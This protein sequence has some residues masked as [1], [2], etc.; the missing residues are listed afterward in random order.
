[1]SRSRRREEAGGGAR[2]TKVGAE[3]SEEEVKGFRRGRLCTRRRTASAP[4]VCVC[5]VNRIFPKKEETFRFRTSLACRGPL[6]FFRQTPTLVANF[7]TLGT[8]KRGSVVARVPLSCHRCVPLVPSRENSGV[9][10]KVIPASGRPACFATVSATK[11]RDLGSVFACLAPPP[12]PPPLLRHFRWTFLKLE[13]IREPLKCE[14]RAIFR[15]VSKTRFLQRRRPPRSPK[16]KRERDG[17]K[18]KRRQAVHSTKAGRANPTVTMV[19]NPV[20]PEGGVRWP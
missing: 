13:S 10:V 16:K 9:V 7:A 6:L 20:P 4:S 3:R 11:W 12:L 15:L 2:T 19:R 14:V 18:P 5:V 8:G 17:P 1:M